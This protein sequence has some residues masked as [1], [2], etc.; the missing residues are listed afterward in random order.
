VWKWLQDW[1]LHFLSQ[2][3]KEILLK[4][5]IQAIPSFCMSVFFLPKLLCAWINSLMTRFWWGH[6]E[7]DKKISWMSWSKMGVPKAC[8]GM[9]FGILLALTKPYWP[10]KFGGCGQCQIALL[11]LL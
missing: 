2:A 1:K 9:G 3:G 5:V 10:N 7:K 4:V 8:G 11:L 6:K